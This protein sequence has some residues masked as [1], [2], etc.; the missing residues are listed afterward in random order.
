MPV[1]GQEV[2]IGFIPSALYVVLIGKVE[3]VQ[4]TKGLDMVKLEAEIVA[5][6][7]AEYAGRQYKTAGAKGTIYCMLDGSQGVDAALSRLSVPLEKLG[8]MEQIPAG[9]N[10]GAPEIEALLKQLE[11]TKVRMTVEC[12]TEYVTDSQVRADAYDI[13][14]AKRDPDNNNEPIVRRYSPRFDFGAVQGV[15]ASSF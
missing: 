5:P 11:N 8:L 4:S 13:S 14:K 3:K 15:H 10:Y 7:V 2:I 9:T 1:R 6:D 12:Q